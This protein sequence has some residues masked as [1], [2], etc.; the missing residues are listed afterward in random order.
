LACIITNKTMFS[1]LTRTQQYTWDQGCK[2]KRITEV[3]VHDERI[4]NKCI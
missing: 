2:A 1:C 3:E 4:Y